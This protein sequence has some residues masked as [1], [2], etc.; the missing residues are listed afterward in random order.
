METNYDVLKT[1]NI[2]NKKGLLAT[3]DTEK[4]FDLVDHSFLSAFSPK[5][6][7]GECFLKW[8]QILI[9]NQ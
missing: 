2:L 1:T 8:I 7:F 6:D 3:A 4:D 9:K 5:Y